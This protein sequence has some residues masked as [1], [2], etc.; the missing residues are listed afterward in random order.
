[1]FHVMI[2]NTAPPK[3]SQTNFFSVGHA[4]GKPNQFKRWRP[5]TEIDH[6]RGRHFEAVIL[7]TPLQEKEKA[8]PRRSDR[9]DEGDSARKAT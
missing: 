9:Y 3:R 2:V 5:T 7:G 1:M 4:R 8:P 6:L